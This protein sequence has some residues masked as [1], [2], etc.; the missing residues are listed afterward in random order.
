MQWPEFTDDLIASFVCAEG[1]DQSIY[2]DGAC[3]GL[4]VRVTR[5]GV[6]SFVFDSKVRQSGGI[7]CRLT[8]G[9]VKTWT[10][11]Q[12]REVAR[13]YKRMTDTGGDPRDLLAR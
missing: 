5:R 8:I 7:K 11:D 13:R 2:W 10:I 1:K 9:S 3:P 4:G 12:A 6:K